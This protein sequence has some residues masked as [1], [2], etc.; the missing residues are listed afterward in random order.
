MTDIAA[1]KASWEAIISLLQEDLDTVHGGRLQAVIEVANALRSMGFDE[2]YF[3]SQSVGRLGLSVVE[4]RRFLKP[5]V[6]ITSR[7]DGTIL[8]EFWTLGRDSQPMTPAIEVVCGSVDAAVTEA[9]R[10][11]AMLPDSNVTA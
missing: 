4:P 1:R 8:C 7:S 10:L 3:A 6:L 11:L 5:H 2:R 9:S